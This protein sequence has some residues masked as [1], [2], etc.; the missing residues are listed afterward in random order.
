MV[1]L[2]LYAGLRNE[3]MCWLKWDSIDWKKRI[4][5]VQETTCELTGESWE[6]K[7]Y[8]A[9]RIDVKEDCID[10]LKEEQ[11]RQKKAK[12]LGVFV[13]P[14]GTIKNR[15]EEDKRKPLYPSSV[16]KSFTKMIRD[17]G[18]DA[19]ITVYSMRHTYATMA[20]RSGIDIR[21]LQK[22]MGHSDIKTTMEYLHFIEPESH[23]MDRLPY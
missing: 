17:E 19:N 7:D 9:R 4:I 18:M 15:K 8:E 21:T 11:K 23:P 22:R 3:E 2:G 1:R 6:P 13:L 20:L 12:L 10:F 16:S 5:N 14:A